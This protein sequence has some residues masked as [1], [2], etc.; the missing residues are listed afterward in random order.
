MLFVFLELSLRGLYIMSNVTSVPASAVVVNQGEMLVEGQLSQ[1]LNGSPMPASM[2]YQR[3]S[4]SNGCDSNDMRE[5]THIPNVEGFFMLSSDGSQQPVQVVLDSGLFFIKTFSGQRFAELA[6]G[7]VLS[8]PLVASNDVS[9]I[10]PIKKRCSSIPSMPK[11]ER[12]SILTQQDFI[13]I[14][15]DLGEALDY[16]ED[17]EAKNND[18]QKSLKKQSSS[19]LVAEYRQAQEKLEGHLQIA[20][21]RAVVAEEEATSAYLELDE[22]KLSYDDVKNKA[23]SLQSLVSSLKQAK[24]AAS[25]SPTLSGEFIA[26]VN[27]IKT[28]LLHV[29]MSSAEP[30]TYKLLDNLVKGLSL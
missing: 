24:E 21:Q 5:Y 15:H 9:N 30:T 7:Q 14:E 1:L 11:F 18:L 8:G 6:N 16:I 27:R 19:K 4:P 20:T 23:D 17:L 26:T 10:K 3:V 22:L 2:P 12:E 28:L 29:K 13:S 25:G